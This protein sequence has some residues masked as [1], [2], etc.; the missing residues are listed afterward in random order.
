MENFID[1]L[2]I[3]NIIGIPSLVVMAG[4]CVKKTIQF[5]KAIKILADAQ[6]KQMRRDLMAD[7]HRFKRQGFI[8][9]ED[10][11]TWEAAYQ[12]Y[13]ALGANGVM[14]SRREELIKMPSKMSHNV[15]D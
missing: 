14:D 15:E 8:E 12:A 3:L 4:W 9:E 6:Q 2:K 11:D 7:Y 1:Y 5:G 13:H 10:L